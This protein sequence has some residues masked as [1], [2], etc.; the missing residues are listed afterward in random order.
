[1]SIAPFGKRFR[2][3]KPKEY[4]KL[5][6]RRLALRFNPFIPSSTKWTSASSS[7]A[8][9]QEYID[10]SVCMIENHQ[11]LKK[12]QTA[13]SYG[14]TNPLPPSKKEKRLPGSNGVNGKE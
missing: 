9:P 10:L 14:S 13:E 1:M 12:I 3:S 7:P 6:Q 8:P 5:C 4:I 11:N 2:G